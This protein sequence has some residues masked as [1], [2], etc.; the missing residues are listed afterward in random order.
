M[1]RRKL[2][3]WAAVPLLLV[4]CAVPSAEPEPEPS[5]PIDQ[6]LCEGRKAPAPVEPPQTRPIGIPPGYIWARISLDI[7]M[8]SP[9]DP[10]EHYCAP[11]GLHV[12]ATYAGGM[13]L[14]LVINGVT[15]PL[16]YDTVTT[17]P[18]GNDLI[19]AYPAG[20]EKFKNA[21]PF[22]DVD[23]QATYFP[24]RDFGPALPMTLACQV[25]VGGQS[26]ATSFAT[27]GVRNYVSCPFRSNFHHGV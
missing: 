13:A 22:Y 26:F 8:T 23:L 19:V 1:T 25:R 20:D 4:G 5:T 3:A 2:A 14:M 16:P 9:T 27:I 12:Y 11:I 10:N 7:T 24:E 18:W 17:T 21:P 15:K 6:A